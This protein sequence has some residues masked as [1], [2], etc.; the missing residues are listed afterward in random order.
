[1][2]GV[3]FVFISLIADEGSL[4]MTFCQEEIKTIK[5]W[6]NDSVRSKAQTNDIKKADREKKGVSFSKKKVYMVYGL[7]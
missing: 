1:M 4:L 2:E 7:P 6:Y 3:Q 5:I